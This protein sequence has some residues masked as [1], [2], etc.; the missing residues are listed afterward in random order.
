MSDIESKRRIFSRVEVPFPIKLVRDSADEIA[1]Y[2]GLDPLAAEALTRFAL[3]NYR[4][5]DIATDFR[6]T[7]ADLKI[8]DVNFNE[9]RTG[10]AVAVYRNDYSRIIQNL[11]TIA[12]N[13]YNTYLSASGS[14]RAAARQVQGIVN[15]LFPP[16]L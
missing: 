11:S 5:K 6:G 12:F 13:L 4:I 3:I 9:D 10:D 15:E 7:T 2:R 14:T 16:A 8:Y 1:Y